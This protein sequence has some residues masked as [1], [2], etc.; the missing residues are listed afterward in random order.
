MRPSSSSSKLLGGK[1]QP[2]GKGSNVLATKDNQQKNTSSHSPKSIHES[3]FLLGSTIS[4]D[5]LTRLCKGPCG[6]ALSFFVEHVKGRQ[7]TAK[8]REMIQCSYES[9]GHAASASSSLNRLKRAQFRLRAV[10]RQIEALQAQ[11]DEIQ[12]RLFTAESEV[13]SLQLQCEEKRLQKLLLSVLTQKENIRI[14]RFADLGNKLE[15]ERTKSFKQTLSEDVSKTSKL[16]PH[17]RLI[18]RTDH[19]RDALAEIQAHVLTLVHLSSASLSHHQLEA[20]ELELRLLRLIAKS[21]NLPVDD[22]GVIAKHTACLDSIRKSGGEE[23]KESK[24]PTDT[25]GGSS[26]LDVDEISERVAR[27]SSR[28]QRTSDEVACLG[29]SCA[30]ALQEID[31][32]TTSTIPVLKESLDEDEVATSGY[33]SALR[34]SIEDYRPLRHNEK[35]DGKGT[36]GRTIA[37]V[38][39]D[40]RK[41]IVHTYETNVLL[42]NAILSTFEPSANQALSIRSHIDNERH[43]STS[44]SQLIQRKVEKSQRVGEVLVSNVET[45]VK[46]VESVGPLT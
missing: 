34:S 39:E 45:L 5:D 35:T 9:Q 13:N 11:H 6:E 14:C 42:S 38:V 4:E 41:D 7:E 27:K 40:V 43:T 3:L 18:I 17:Q 32:F 46:E 8:A 21:M 23:A 15:S 16:K 19:T 25:V 24:S 26:L 12:R 10:D 37:Q 28:L 20:Q 44:S 30:E 33:V 31:T 22:E 2:E 36:E 1:R 29:T